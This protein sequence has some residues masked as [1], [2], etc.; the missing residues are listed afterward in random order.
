MAKKL[1][2]EEVDHINQLFAET[3]GGAEDEEDPRP[4]CCGR[5]RLCLGEHCPICGEKIEN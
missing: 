1:T 3:S 4:T 5:I 2:P